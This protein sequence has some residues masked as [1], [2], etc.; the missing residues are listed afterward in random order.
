M[1]ETKDLLK[2]IL[3]VQVAT[4]AVVFLNVPVLRAV[5]GFIYLSF[6]PGALILDISKL[7]SKNKLSFILLSIG[8][9]I[10]FVMFFGALINTLL[11][12]VGIMSPLS[13][14]PLIL[15]IGTALLVM[16]FAALKRDSSAEENSLPFSHV[17]LKQFLGVPLLFAIPVLTIFGAIYSN[18]LLL[19]VTVALTA[20]LVAVSFVS[21][22][23]PT[24][25]KPIVILV[26][27]LSVLFQISFM[28]PHLVGFDIYEEFYAFRVTQANSWWNPALN[29]SENEIVA[30]NGM[31]S[32]TV[33]PTVYSNWLN[34]SGEWIFRFIY[35]LFYSLVPLTMY[36]M[37]RQPF[38]KY[39]AFLAA[40]YFILFPRFYDEE[41]RQ[42]VGELFLVLLI[43]L[44]LSPNI[45]LQK[46]RVLAIVFGAA[47]IVSHYSTFYIFLFCALFAWVMTTFLRRPRL[48]GSEA[49]AK[50]IVTSS[51]L[52]ALLILGI[53]WYTY[54]TPQLGNGFAQLATTIVRSFTGD[55]T[56][57]ESRGSG[58]SDFVAPNLGSMS[59]ISQ[60][61]AIINKIPYVLIVAGFVAIL[62]KFRGISLQPEYFHMV[63]VNM[64]ILALVLTVPTL[65]PA[66]LPQRFYH[67]SLIFL[68][69]VCIL[70]GAAL[71]KLVMNPFKRIKKKKAIVFRILCIF[72]IVIFLFKVGFV[73]EITKDPPSNIALSFTRM[74][75]STNPA[76][77]MS[78]YNAYSPEVDVRSAVWLSEFKG[79]TSSA[80][81]DDI[82]RKHVV[83]A[84]G[85]IIVDWYHTLHNDTSIGKDSYAYLRCINVDGIIPDHG[86]ATNGTEL[87]NQLGSTN[88]VYS[89]GES[90]IYYSPDNPP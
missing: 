81:A 4:F 51:L 74:Q 50:R 48:D 53:S 18:T 76:M 62:R 65:A 24:Q 90:A 39:V 41:R 68:A 22:I 83:V 63:T 70:G 36:Q 64:L 7:S 46:K 3:I 21:K 14:L 2:L 44:I 67:I 31:L 73:S 75:S 77:L 29:V 19:L 32:L 47:L 71:L 6:V 10:A 13:T 9:S 88:Q 66:F 38:G 69:P 17:N 35:I 16:S 45:S 1:Y 85:M 52:L 59:W 56:S 20:L 72:F 40:F 43:F 58:V 86:S 82:A 34:I 42:I 55:F 28:S 12:L 78:L 54:V 57:L 11:P 26:I 89:N 33:L 15:L 23:I 8:L 25:L 49:R 5:L 80:Y 60:I 30:Y 61:D 79:S 37:Y 84:Y 27:A 87:L